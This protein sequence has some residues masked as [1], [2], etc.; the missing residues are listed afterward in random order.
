MI[1][2]D[3]PW[4]LEVAWRRVCH[5]H[6]EVIEVM[7]EDAQDADCWL[8]S[9]WQLPMPG[10]IK[11]NVDGSF[12]DMSGTGGVGG[13]AR[14]AHGN[15][16]FGFIAHTGGGNA[17]TAE[18]EAL[19]LGM[20]LVWDRGYREVMVEVDCA[21]LLHGIEDEDSRQ[22]LPVLSEIKQLR[23]RAWNI[24][25]V[26]VSRECNAPADF[27]AKMGARSPGI[28]FSFLDK[29]PWEVETLV[30]RDRMLVR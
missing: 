15:W 19:L 25:V 14:D 16:L 29:P 4:S 17:L 22:F 23:D 24:S 2:E 18:A 21:E 30:L 12:R 8:E 11:L 28:N 9:R 7:G 3:S 10:S 13:L 20:K 1:F 6:D 5:E 27:L 26:R